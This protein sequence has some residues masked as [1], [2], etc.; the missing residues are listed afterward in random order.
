MNWTSTTIRPVVF[1]D[2]SES[3]EEAIAEK[4]CSMIPRICRSVTV[5]DHPGVAR[6]PI[7]DTRR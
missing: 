4:H 3:W 1:L 2:S 5:D 7:L 6:R